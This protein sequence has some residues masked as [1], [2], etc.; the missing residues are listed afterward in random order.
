MHKR[1]AER[2]AGRRLDEKTVTPP[3]ICQSKAQYCS[4]RNMQRMEGLGG[5]DTEQHIHHGQTEQQKS[6]FFLSSKI[7]IHV[8]SGCKACTVAL[9][10]QYRLQLYCSCAE[11]NFDPAQLL[12][13]N[14]HFPSFFSQFE[15]MHVRATDV[16]KLPL[17]STRGDFLHMSVCN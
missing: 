2:H 13:K 10:L 9:Q 8:H 3:L 4:R 12:I 14:K 17:S 1:R 6:N 7:L 11:S 5:V 15:S 16:S